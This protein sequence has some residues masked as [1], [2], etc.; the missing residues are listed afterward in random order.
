MNFV[1]LNTRAEKFEVSVSK[2]KKKAIEQ[3]EEL[4]RIGYSF[5][6]RFFIISPFFQKLHK[7]LIKSILANNLLWQHSFV[8]AQISVSRAIT[9]WWSSIALSFE[10]LLI[11]TKSTLDIIIGGANLIALLLIKLF[12]FFVCSIFNENTLFLHKISFVEC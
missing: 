7:L 2:D 3:R 5:Y 1:I 6:F 4:V 11:I 10:I 8:S 9:K 12:N